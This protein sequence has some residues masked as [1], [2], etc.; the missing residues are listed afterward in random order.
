MP[1]DTKLILDACALLRWLQDEA[2]A[3]RVELFLNGAATGHYQVLMH[4]MN[5]GEVIYIIAKDF[6][7]DLAQRKKE[8][9]GLLPISIL[10]FSEA[11]F[12]QAVELKAHHAMSYADCFAAA[13]A[14]HEHATLLTSD[15]EFEVLR[16][17]ITLE[18]V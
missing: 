6:G 18:R 15:P 11:N 14:I 10:P 16:H 12:W 1:N 9:I 8:E 7:W 17:L 4:I 2:G 3:S 13:A 5:L